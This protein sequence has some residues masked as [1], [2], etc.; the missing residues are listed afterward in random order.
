LLSATVWW[1]RCENDWSLS[2]LRKPRRLPGQGRILVSFLCDTYQPIEERLGV[3]RQDL[4][5]LLRAGHHV[6]IQTWTTLVRRDFGLLS[7]YKDQVR[8][9]TSLSHLDDDL[10]RSL[11]PTAR[12][13]MLRE[14]SQLRTPVYVAVAPLLPIHKLTVMDDVVARVTPLHPTEILCEALNLACL[15]SKSQTAAGEL[16]DSGN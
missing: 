8:L 5:H 10:A 7:K 9:G 1:R 12:L 16:P 11:V 4:E 13:E 6:R 2:S 15:R 14:A 3:T